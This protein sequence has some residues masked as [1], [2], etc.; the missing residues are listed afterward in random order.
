VFEVDG[1]DIDQLVTTIDSLDDI[2]DDTPKLIISRT[3]KGKGVAFMEDD[4]LWHYAGL[5]PEMAEDA[6]KSIDNT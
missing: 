3:V 6:F 4:P 5:S 2:P 1:H